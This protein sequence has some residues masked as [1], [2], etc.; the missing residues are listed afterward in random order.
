MRILW[1]SGGRAL[2]WAMINLDNTDA[3]G[4]VSV[5]VLLVNA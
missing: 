3:R 5:T 4:Q 2:V 1:R